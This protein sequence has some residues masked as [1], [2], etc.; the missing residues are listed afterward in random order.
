MRTRISSGLPLS[1]SG[2][3]VEKRNFKADKY[4]IF[5]SWEEDQR[6]DYYIYTITVNMTVNTSATTVMPTIS[7]EGRY[8]D[9]INISIEASNCAGSSEN[10]TKDVYE[11]IDKIHLYCM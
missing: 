11:G 9:F 2:V 3:N 1:P 4:S 7:F 6:A 10:I 5:I 8:N